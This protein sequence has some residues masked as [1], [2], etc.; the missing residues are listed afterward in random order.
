MRQR[1]NYGANQDADDGTFWI[2]FQDFCRN[3]S[4]LNMCRLFETIEQGGQWHKATMVADWKG[5]NA[6]GCPQPGNKNSM[7]NPQY[8][9]KLTRPGHVF[10]QLEQT[11]LG[12]KGGRIQHEDKA[13]ICAFILK[14]KGKRLG[15][16]IYGGMEANSAPFVNSN[17]VTVDMT[18]LKVNDDGYTIVCTTFNKAKEAGIILTVYSDAPFAPDCL[19][20]NEETGKMM[21]TRMY[22]E[23]EP[24]KKDGK[25]FPQSR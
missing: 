25:T 12:Q 6:G 13:S 23:K 19:I 10:I 15:N 22:H 21:L 7:Y 4:G 14:L 1:L 17:V 18:K 20:A 5:I 3:F 8:L 24:V 2:S 16:G 9:L 11:K